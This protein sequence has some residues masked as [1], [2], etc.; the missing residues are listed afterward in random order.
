M[1][2]YAVF[3]RLIF[4]KRC[5]YSK[6]LNIINNK[7]MQMKAKQDHFIYQINKDFKRL[8]VVSTDK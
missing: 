7:G 6:M 3:Y 8:I 1:D 4:I 2:A 5:L